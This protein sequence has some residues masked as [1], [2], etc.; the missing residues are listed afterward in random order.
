MADPVKGENTSVNLSKK[1]PTKALRAFSVINDQLT[2]DE[3]VYRQ[4]FCVLTM[5]ANGLQ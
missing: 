1:E 3:Y 5:C 4:T 2:S